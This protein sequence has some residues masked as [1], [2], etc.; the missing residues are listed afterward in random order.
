MIKTIQKINESEEEEF[1]YEGLDDVAEEASK[2]C[3]IN[4]M[5]CAVHTLQL[6][7]RNPMLQI[8][9]ASLGRQQ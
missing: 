9:L 3:L 4:H 2:L 1:P 6:A 8:S 7:I 5:C